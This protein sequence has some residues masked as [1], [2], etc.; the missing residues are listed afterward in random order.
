MCCKRKIII[1]INSDHCSIQIID[2]FNGQINCM[3]IMVFQNCHS[4]IRRR[5]CMI[6][7]NI[8][9]TTAVSIWISTKT[10]IAIRSLF[11]SNFTGIFLF[12][13]LCGNCSGTFLFRFYTS[14]R[15]YRSNR[16][17][18]TCPFYFSFC[19]SYF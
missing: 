19:S 14:F 13:N 10:A 7:N 15:R 3:V 9:F 6:T 16:F 5:F 4:S 18:A 8:L 12:T 1:L 17:F 11:H 2:K